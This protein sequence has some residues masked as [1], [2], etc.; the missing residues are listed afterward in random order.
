MNKFLEEFPSPNFY[1]FYEYLQDLK[2]EIWT[3]SPIAPDS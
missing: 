1:F 2:G 3:K